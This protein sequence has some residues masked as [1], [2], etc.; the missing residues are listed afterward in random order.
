MAETVDIYL[1][2]NEDWGRSLYVTDFD[3]L[4]ID[5]TGC[6]VALQVREKL[7]QD[8]IA[9]AQCSIPNPITGDVQV[10]LRA[11][12]GSALSTYG[13]PIQIANLHYDC[14][15]TDPDGFDTIL[16]GGI[17]VLSRGETRA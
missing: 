14:R 1:Q 9:S 10:I 13:A 15:L 3:G 8:L 12:E 11:S 6:T 16:F 5:L 4:P 7:T 2:R 17:V